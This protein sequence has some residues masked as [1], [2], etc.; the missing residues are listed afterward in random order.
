MNYIRFFISSTF[1]D[2]TKERD[3]INRVLTDLRS[4]LTG[5]NWMIEWVD[6][7]WG[8]SQEASLDNRTMRICIDEL[9]RCRE[10]SP[11]PNFIILAGER[12]GWLPLP[13]VI[14][15]SDVDL[16]I[17]KKL[18][19]GDIALFSDWY[20]LDRNA[21]PYGEYILQPRRNEFVDNHIYE[22]LVVSDLRRILS[23]ICKGPTVEKLKLSATAQE[24]YCG[25][26]GL[27]AADTFVY[28]RHLA[29]IPP[30]FQRVFKDDD[31]DEIEKIKELYSYI[32]TLS[33]QDNNMYVY[34]EY[35]DYVAGKYD[36]KIEAGMRSHLFRIISK[37]IAERQEKMPATENDFH[38]KI[39]SDLKKKLVGRK[40]IL[41]D[42]LE[43]INSNDR[44]PL[45]I[46][47][48]SGIGKSSLMAMLVNYVSD[49]T[50]NAVIARFCG[51]TQES[52]E[53]WALLNSIFIDIWDYSVNIRQFRKPIA[54][55]RNLNQMRSGW[56]PKDI[57][58][59]KCNRKV[60]VIIDSI[61]TVDASQAKFF[62][63]LKWMDVVLSDNIK[64]IVTT[65]PDA[66]TDSSYNHIQCIP[67]DG[68]GEES[69]DV[70]DSILA[71][72]HRTLSSDQFEH[73]QDA[74]AASD[75]SGI[76]LSLLA[77]HLIDL[78]SWQK[79]T[80][81]PHT[82]DSLL[83]LILNNLRNPEKHGK[84]IV[85]LSLCLL[86]A[87][88]V[89]LSDEEMFDLLASDNLLADE[90]RANAMQILSSDAPLVP[91]I[92][93]IRLQSD[94]HGLIKK[95]QTPAGFHTMLAHGQI[96]DYIYR[97]IMPDNFS[98]YQS[99]ESIYNY[100]SSHIT[101]NYTHSIYECARLAYNMI[102]CAEAINNAQ[103]EFSEMLD[104]SKDL[105]RN[106]LINP[107]YIINKAIHF[108][109]DLLKEYSKYG[110][111]LKD[112][113]FMVR[114]TDIG[115][116]VVTLPTACDYEAMRSY[117]F[118]LP[119][120]SELRKCIPFPSSEKMLL[121][122]WKNCRI[123]HSITHPVYDV[124]ESPNIGIEGNKIASLFD[125]GRLL[126]IIDYAVTDCEDIIIH[127]GVTGTKL[128]SDDMLKVH[129][130]TAKECILLIESD[131]RKILR[132]NV[133]DANGYISADGRY[134]TICQSNSCIQ[135]DRLKSS[136]YYFECYHKSAFPT[137]SG[138][139]VWLIDNE[140]NL[141][142]TD[143]SSKTSI[144]IKNAEEILY[145]TEDI[146]VVKKST[147]IEIFSH[148]IIQGH[149]KFKSWTLPYYYVNKD[150][151]WFDGSS[152]S[153]FLSI[154]KSLQEFKV[155]KDSLSVFSH[156]TQPD[157]ITVKGEYALR[158]SPSAIV[159]W[160]EMLDEVNIL[161]SFNSGI[162]SFS[163][164]SDGEVAT[165]TFGINHMQE[166]YRY[167]TM[168]TDEGYKKVTLPFEDNNF[169]YITSAAV[170]PDRK[171][172]GAS[173]ESGEI[174]LVNLSDMSLLGNFHSETEGCLG[175]SF[176]PDSSKMLAVGDHFIASP[177][178]FV[179]VGDTSTGVIKPI[180]GMPDW[181]DPENFNLMP[182]PQGESRFMLDD[183]FVSLGSLDIWDIVNQR[184]VFPANTEIPFHYT[185]LPKS[186]HNSIGHGP[187]EC[188]FEHPQSG[189]LMCSSKGLQTEIDLLSRT[190]RQYEN[191]K[192]LIGI[193]ADGN[194]LFYLDSQSNL[195]LYC[196]AFRRIIAH[197]IVAVYPSIFF[198]NEV[199]AYNRSGY[200]CLISIYG[201]ELAKAYVPDLWH[202]IPT[203]R[204]LAIATPQ[205][206]MLLST[207]SMIEILK[208]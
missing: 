98:R 18:Q 206:P 81:F 104:Y 49:Y 82:L 24:I 153:L 114:L 133:T 132:W 188:I 167:I 94:L 4:Q 134:V 57:F 76:Y 17:L 147:E 33:Q 65:T 52:S 183:G 27:T 125:N 136:H 198:P 126:K 178:P 200:V 119:D 108:R 43:Y 182:W 142:R 193:S 175:I 196:S 176:S 85:N 77:N 112:S 143:F 160:Q 107:D 67:L 78:P 7:R 124:G 79:V 16:D 72:K 140:N 168:M 130:V 100:L 103:G 187:M 110:S 194:F 44:H 156:G 109:S 201:D 22:T 61:N 55:E 12:Y 203:K 47:A 15:F 50:D 121:D 135:F 174:I 93:W 184:M 70:I 101:N 102:K 159:R 2:M 90:V 169:D 84:R 172:L 8:I 128:V 150:Q 32:D 92:L 144:G 83:D 35:N 207:K 34:G 3:I 26:D 162:G 42:L 164:S 145:A 180:S 170:S 165:M 113:H 31:A 195:W 71:R 173:S 36:E 161:V 9:N 23:I 199:F 58:T 51:E 123:S 74:V 41:N 46:S 97:R 68:M 185:K 38:L 45:L 208:E 192:D 59:L 186:G 64:V 19:E 141:I 87:S 202:A 73:V 129:V 13:E 154:G 91:R 117:I 157:L 116:D 62:F 204:G 95:H 37:V 190:I 63:S 205:G 89:G 10:L 29:N 163:V 155:R 189:L 137:Y 148:N 75:Q 131:T 149:H 171:F 14:P 30:K 197:E 99:Y 40:G 11:R 118:N 122:I 86:A 158:V 60:I 66:V 5:N 106:L 54:L 21:L 120:N 151:I 20:I 1:A 138:R 105:L 115:N 139:F 56:N 96:W 111:I 28:R 25:L 88:S 39:A 48:P 179:Y 152:D 69:M 166:S 6:L 191:D 80:T 177:P 127:L 146:C 181:Q 53:A